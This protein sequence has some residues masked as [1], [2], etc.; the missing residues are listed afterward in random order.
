VETFLNNV[1]SGADLI[2]SRDEIFFENGQPKVFVNEFEKLQRLKYK[3]YVSI[4]NIC[5]I[6]FCRAIETV[7]ARAWLKH[8]LLQFINNQ[9]GKR[10]IQ[11]ADQDSIISGEQSSIA[12]PEDDEQ[13]FRTEVMSGLM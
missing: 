11:V 3:D 6:L 7:E 1:Q 12:D 4:S 9:K 10:I 5:L 13:E 8:R 2:S